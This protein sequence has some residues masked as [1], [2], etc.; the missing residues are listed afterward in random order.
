MMEG[1]KTPDWLAWVR[2]LRLPNV[3]TVPGDVLAGAALAG[4]PFAAQG[5]P[6]AGVSLAYLFGMALNDVADR[7]EDGIHRPERPLPAGRIPIAAAR[8][9]TLLLACAALYSH[10]VPGM[11]FLI[12][13]ICAYNGMK[14]VFPLLGGFLMALCRGLA[15]WIGAGAP[16]FLSPEIAGAVGLWMLFVFGVTRFAEREGSPSPPKRL[17]WYFPSLFLAAFP[18]LWFLTQGSPWALLPA[19]VT[20]YGAIRLAVSLQVEGSIRPSHTGALLMLLFP[21]QTTILFLYE[22]WAAGGIILAFAPL[23][24]LTRKRVPPS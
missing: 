19:A 9:M 18:F 6:V 1:M 4:L 3:M 7:K 15:V 20:I 23:L 24:R 12:A 10:P 13:A 11:V 17:G 21:M 8:W 16:G 5:R 22:A 14:S 2:F